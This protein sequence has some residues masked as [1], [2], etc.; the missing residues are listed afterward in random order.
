MSALG[1]SMLV[2]LGAV[3]GAIG[4]EFWDFANGPLTDDQYGALAEHFNRRLA[5][6]DDESAAIKEMLVPLK[7][8]D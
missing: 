8:L 4:V 6:C 1:L 5:V 2:A 7:S 3:C